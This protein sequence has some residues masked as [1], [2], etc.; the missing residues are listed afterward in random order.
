MSS[1]VHYHLELKVNEDHVLKKMKKEKKTFMKITKMFIHIE[2]SL[3]VHRY[4]NRVQGTTLQSTTRFVHNSP[5][6]S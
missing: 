2:Y 5:H 1:E 4:Y 6:A 3:Q